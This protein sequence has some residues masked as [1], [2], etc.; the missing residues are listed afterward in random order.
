MLSIILFIIAA[1]VVAYLAFLAFGALALGVMSIGVAVY[2]IFYMIKKKP[3]LTLLV[4]IPS[5][6]LAISFNPISIL[7]FLVYWLVLNHSIKL[8]I[9]NC[10]EKY[11]HSEFTD[12]KYFII[13]S[14]IY[15]IKNKL[16]YEDIFITKYVINKKYDDIL[17]DSLL[18]F[19]NEEDN[20]IVE[21]EQSKDII[22]DANYYNQLKEE[23]L[24]TLKDFIISKIDSDNIVSE[25]ELMQFLEKSY[26]NKD[27]K[28]SEIKNII[29]QFCKNDLFNELT[30][31]IDLKSKVLN[32]E[33]Y[34]YDVNYEDLL[35]VEAY[36][37]LYKK[38]SDLSSEYG[39][40]KFDLDNWLSDY[41]KGE[42]SKIEFI[43]DFIYIKSESIL[44]RVFKEL[45]IIKCKY[46]Q[47]NLNQYCFN[48]D[49]INK[50]LQKYIDYDY[51]R[52]SELQNIFYMESEEQTYYFFK[53]YKSDYSND[54]LKPFSF[55]QK[56]NHVVIKYDAVSKFRCSQCSKIDVDYHLYD[57]KIYCEDC[58]KKI[59]DEE[60]GEKG[61][62]TIKEI[63]ESDIPPHILAKLK[64][65]ESDLKKNG[66]IKETD[67]SEIPPCI[68][69][70]LK[71]KE[72]DL[73]KNGEIKETDN[74][75]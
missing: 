36:G 26:L 7:G 18:K 49:N 46:S 1:I 52:L 27:D 50:K 24:S 38:I 33:Y 10:L 35:N 43:K 13:D 37:V 67:E 59:R 64:A 56:F 47:Y 54:V 4:L 2:N 8:E 72:S 14:F 48:I 32:D 55:D 62:K 41:Y 5:I 6:L 34:Y 29:F 66:E 17:Q 20:N 12:K 65:K 58:Y 22:V 74:I 28:T 30:I 57:D 23:I 42:A 16:N 45:E 44:E 61:R 3:F 39:V 70:K 31:K 68:Q 69:A 60:N 75:C 21:I 15:Q 51:I 11:I 9:R 73:K 63:D 53:N 71:A 40:F 19:K 25:R